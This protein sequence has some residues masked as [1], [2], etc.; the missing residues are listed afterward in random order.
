MGARRSRCSSL[1]NTTESRL[2]ST[3]AQMPPLRASSL[4][5]V[6][7]GIFG[8]HRKLPARGVSPSRLSV[9]TGCWLPGLTSLHYLKP[10]GGA[11][12]ECI[13]S[14]ILEFPV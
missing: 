3:A 4:L 8:T 5:A 10:A 12:Y 13:G 6:T 2:A 1:D 9:F 7:Q 14:K 11:Q